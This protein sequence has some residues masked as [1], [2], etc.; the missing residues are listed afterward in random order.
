MTEQRYPEYTVCVSNNT[1]N[2]T[3]GV[4]STRVVNIDEVKAKVRATP[5]VMDT[6]KLSTEVPPA[7]AFLSCSLEELRKL[8]INYVHIAEV[9]KI[10]KDRIRLN[11]F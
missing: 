6:E 1:K 10:I 8:E 4:H 5:D 3:K 2:I 9:L 7:V 11:G